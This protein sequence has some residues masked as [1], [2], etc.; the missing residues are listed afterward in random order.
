MELT[1]HRIATL[2]LAIL[3]T[4]SA[5]ASGSEAR[6]ACVPAPERLSAPEVRVASAS[7]LRKAVLAAN[8]GGPKHIVIEP[9]RYRVPNRGLLLAGDGL[10]IRGATGRRDDVVIEGG[11]PS[12]SA[13][14]VFLVRGSDTVLRD[15]SLGRVKHHV[16]QIQGERDADRPVLHNLRIYDAGQQ[17]VKVSGG[18]SDVRSDA[19]RVSN[20]LF[21]YTAGQAFQAY[22]GGIDA[23]KVAGWIIHDN[24]FMHIRSP[25]DGLAEHAIHLWSGSEDNRV[26][27]NLIV[28]ADRGIGFGL[29][30]RGNRG[31]VIINNFVHTTRDVGI[32]LESSPGT[33]VLHNTVFTE[34]YPNS[35]E[36]RFESTRDVF[37][38]S[39]LTNARLHARNGGS[40]ELVAN[41][42]YAK[43]NWF[44]NPKAGDL[45]VV[46]GIDGVRG[47]APADSRVSNDFDCERRDAGGGFDVGA[48]QTAFAI[49]T[50]FEVT[51][52]SKILVAIEDVVDRGRERLGALAENSDN[53]GFI[54]ALLGLGIV[55][56]LANLLMTWWLLARAVRELRTMR[57]ELAALRAE[58]PRRGVSACE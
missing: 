56:L 9:G 55:L 3:T 22:A 16:V 33:V 14:H 10:T 18:K 35:V 13:T 46:T 51:R 28:N 57:N 24:V 37:L 41:V 26:E 23:H 52:P 38:G 36:Y 34:N 31:G 4:V 44:K 27:R 53:L 12:G 8:A 40:A 11:G 2:A 30:E 25:D 29:G 43:A 42:D 58:R 49:D 19:G 17:L 6:R 5:P 1:V 48:D 20:S 50:G 54:A 39:N 32:G 15:M 21:E 7:A 47:A 45:H